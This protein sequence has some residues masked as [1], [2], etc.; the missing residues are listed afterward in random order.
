M[1]GAWEQEDPVPHGPIDRGPHNVPVPPSHL[2]LPIALTVRL[3]YHYMVHEG[4]MGIPRIEQG[5]G[6]IDGVNVTFF[7]PT[8][9]YGAGSVRYYLNGQLQTDDNVV[10]VGPSSG[11]VRVDGNGQ[12]PPRPGDIVQFFYMDESGIQPDPFAG[13]RICVVFGELNPLEEF[14]GSIEDLTIS[15]VID[16]EAAIVGTVTEERP[17]SGEIGDV[18]EISGSLRAC[19]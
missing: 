5:V 7:T 11:E 16:A 3:Q 4:G 13:T 9:P 17:F 15:G 8:A 6:P 14:E 10:E 2:V 12:I 19:T 1:D 18:I